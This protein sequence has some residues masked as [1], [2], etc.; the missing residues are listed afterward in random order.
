MVI[1][2]CALMGCNAP[3]PIGEV[4][5]YLG[6]DVT[7]D[8]ANGKGKLRSVATLSAVGVGA[9]PATRYAACSAYQAAVDRGISEIY[10]VGL[11]T[12][13]NNDEWTAVGN[14]IISP[15]APM[16]A[17]WLDTAATLELCR[18]RGTPTS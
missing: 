9:V 13:R 5:Q 16:G 11:T 18:E 4:T 12:D 2:S 7:I 3:D 6:S 17:T 1:A 15:D 8:V 14:Y 10:L